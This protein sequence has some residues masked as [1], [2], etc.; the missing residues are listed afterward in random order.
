MTTQR[1]VPD[2]S[3]MSSDA[4]DAGILRGLMQKHPPGMIQAQEAQGQKD[5]V[6]STQLPVKGTDGNEAAW[7][8][9]GVE[10]LPIE[11]SDIFRGAVLPAGWKK[12]RTDHSMWSHLVDETGKVRAEIFYKAAFYDRSAF[13]RIS[14]DE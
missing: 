2:T 5:L 11:G 4:M 13:V 10:L 1:R 9:L 3:D 6:A 8:D 12:V 7:T 14:K